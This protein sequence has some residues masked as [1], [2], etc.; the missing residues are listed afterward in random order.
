M[1]IYS[2]K[3]LL[4]ILIII[5]LS[6]YCIKPSSPLL[7][8]YWKL[9]LLF[10]L[11]IYEPSSLLLKTYSQNHYFEWLSTNHHHF[12][13]H[14]NDNI[15]QHP[16]EYLLTIIIFTDNLLTHIIIFMEDLLIQ[17][18]SLF[19]IEDLLVVRRPEKTQHC[20]NRTGLLPLV[21][22]SWMIGTLP[23]HFHGSVQSS[24]YLS[25]HLPSRT[26]LESHELHWNKTTVV[27]IY[28]CTFL[29]HTD[30]WDWFNF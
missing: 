8:T 5:S 28:A 1:I 2:I 21:W 27:D 20:P 13:W 7:T 9:W 18:S 16:F 22:Y 30:L 12:Y 6:N 23:V 17:L 11:S 3:G 25:D 29:N 14:S 26:P 10:L 24:G 4:T 19:Y 15:V